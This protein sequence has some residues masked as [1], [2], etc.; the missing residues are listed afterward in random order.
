MP[1]P[2]ARSLLGGRLLVLVAIALSAFTLRVAVTSFTP[3]AEQIGADI[4]FSA[5]VVGIFGMVPTAMFAVSGLGTPAVAVRLGLERTAVLAMLMAGTGMLARALVHDVWSMLALSALALAG[6]GMGNV[7]IPPLVKRYFGDR[8]AL[9]SSLYIA[10]VQLGTVLPALVAVPVADQLGW[11]ASIGLWSLVGFA[12]A[13]P[14]LFILR[15]RRTTAERDAAPRQS[16][17]PGRGR[18][19]HSSVGWGLAIMF[20]ATSLTTYAMFT[21][22]PKILTDAGASDAFGGA[23]VALFAAVGLAAA[24]TVPTLATRMLNPFPIVV[25]CAV[26]YAIGFA[27]LYWAPMHAPAL[28][29]FFIGLGPST[30]PLAL[31]LINLRT[32]TPAGSQALSGFSQGLGYTIACLGPVLFG[33]L[34][35]ATHG[36]GAPFAMLG[37]V[38]CVQVS[39]G[40]VACRPRMLEDSWV[41][42]DRRR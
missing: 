30:F 41:R 14:W 5:T 18:P 42:S 29:V 33:M 10:L 40:W 34:H 16:T 21:W 37:L 12:A 17:D 6:M 4:G 35:N 32:R 22:I 39:A 7:V 19:W 2:A 24:L 23:M 26:A 15:D 28:W 25:V 27:G 38:V 9:L 11:R 36:W 3:L 8:L 20:G 1:R 13:L 31:T